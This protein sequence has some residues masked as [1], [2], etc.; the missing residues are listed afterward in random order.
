MLLFE[1]KCQDND[2]IAGFKGLAEFQGKGCTVT[3]LLKP[4]DKTTSKQ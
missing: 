2:T 4:R 3:L 1:T